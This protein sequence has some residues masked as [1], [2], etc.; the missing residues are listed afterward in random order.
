MIDVREIGVSLRHLALLLAASVLGGCVH[1][2]PQPISPPAALTAIESRA[3]DDPEVG[4]FLQAN[5]EPTPWPPRAWD[6]RAL[7]LVAFYYHSDLDVARSAWVAAQAAIVTAGERPNPNVSVAP[8][9]NSTTPASLVTPWILTLDLDFA[10]ETAGKR[11]H[12]IAEARQISEAARLNIA[13]VAWQVRSRVRRSLLELYAATETAALLEQQ[14]GIQQGN[15]ALLERQL[16]AGAISP[17]EL[18]QARLVLDTI[19]LTVH[20]ALRRQAEARVEL[21]GALGLTVRA[22]DGV[23]LAFEAF[24]RMP[25]ELPAPDARRQAL[26]NRPDILGALMEYGGRQAALQ[27]EIA[28]QYPDI[29]LGPGYQMDQDSNKWTLGFAGLLPVFSRNRGPIAEAEARR[30]EAA[31]RFTSVQ[32]RAIEEIDRALAAY[33]AALAK[34]A[35]ADA[36]YADRQKQGRGADTQ[37]TAGEISRLELGS[38]QLELASSEQARLD[39]HVSAQQ[40]LGQLE[41]A[42]QSPAELADWLSIAP[43]LN[44]SGIKDHR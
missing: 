29:H 37:F 9:Y 43:R 24:D 23:S 14:Q 28:R 13:S 2:Q 15:I 22:L 34:V 27:L 8:G 20:D 39:A 35:T 17:F 18:T 44:P 38:I 25:S 26:L 5:H 33:R 21:A 31:A 11:G 12:R 41:D 7:T 3:L 32:S 36:L 19:R 4:R 16:A 42:M 6:L 10:I 40:A 1:F 30:E